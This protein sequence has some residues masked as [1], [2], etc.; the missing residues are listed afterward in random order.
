VAVVMPVFVVMPA[1]FHVAAA[2]TASAFFAHKIVKY[3][4]SGRQSAPFFTQSQSRLT[5]A[6]TVQRFN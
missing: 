4:S 1:D 2:E 5:S 3:R 6:A